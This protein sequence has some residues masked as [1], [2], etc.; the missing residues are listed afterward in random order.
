[1]YR[2]SAN[3]GYE[4]MEMSTVASHGSVLTPS[5]SRCA[6]MAARCRIHG[7]KPCSLSY[8]SHATMGMH[9]TY[10]M[11]QD[12]RA[13]SRRNTECSEQTSWKGWRSTVHTINPETCC[14]FGLGIF[15]EH[16]LKR[17]CPCKKTYLKDNWR[18]LMWRFRSTQLLLRILEIKPE[19]VLFRVFD[20]MFVHWLTKWTTITMINHMLLVY[21]NLYGLL[22]PI[23]V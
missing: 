22:S 10:S 11:S 20:H 2:S 5:L 7:G 19:R 17:I 16:P 1:M 14:S 21:W 15:N 8:G 13:W 6:V 23:D 4:V 9:D 12:H 18:Y 3:D